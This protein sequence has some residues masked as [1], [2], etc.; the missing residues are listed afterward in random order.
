MSYSYQNAAWSIDLHLNKSREEYT[1]NEN[2]NLICNQALV[3][4]IPILN[5]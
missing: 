2:M 1:V 4:K 3:Y 5:I